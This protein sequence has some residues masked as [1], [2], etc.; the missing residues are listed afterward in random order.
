MENAVEEEI[1]HRIQAAGGVHVASHNPYWDHN[2]VTFTDPD[3]YLC[4][5]STRSWS[6]GVETL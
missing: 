3:G 2:G 6:N 5:L 1:I 4:V